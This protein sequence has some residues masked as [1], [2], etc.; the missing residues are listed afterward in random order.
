MLTTLCQST[1]CPLSDRAVD[2]DPGAP[3]RARGR[4]HALGGDVP[5]LAGTIR[6][7]RIAIARNVRGGDALDLT[8][9]PSGAS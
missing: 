1:R 3:V 5:R 9:L 7:P 2:A 8:S 4:R 6:A